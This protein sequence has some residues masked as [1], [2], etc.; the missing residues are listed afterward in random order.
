MTDRE[1]LEFLAAHGALVC[2][3]CGGW[4]LRECEVCAWRELVDDG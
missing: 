3:V 2:P 1:W 4:Y